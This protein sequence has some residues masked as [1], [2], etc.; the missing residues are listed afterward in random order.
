[1]V[2]PVEEVLVVIE[3]DQHQYHQ[4]LEYMQSQLVLVEIVEIVLQMEEIVYFL[5]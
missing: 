1:V 5:L 2:K 3:L 4:H